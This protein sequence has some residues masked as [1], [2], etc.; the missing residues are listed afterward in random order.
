MKLLGKKLKVFG[1]DGM[2]KLHYLMDH[3]RWDKRFQYE[4]QWKV[5]IN[6]GAPQEGSIPL[7][8]IQ[9]F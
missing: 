4:V 1:E 2:T 5:Y 6:G 3:D 9:Y 7:D 8:Y